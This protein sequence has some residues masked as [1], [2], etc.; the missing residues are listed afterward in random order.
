M[1]FASTN[2]SSGTYAQETKKIG[3]GNLTEDDLIG[4][5]YFIFGKYVY[6]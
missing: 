1:S 6:Q 4:A 2:L 5:W 3:I